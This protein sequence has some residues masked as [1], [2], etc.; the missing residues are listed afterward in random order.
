MPVIILTRSVSRCSGN[1]W[2]YAYIYIRQGGRI[3]N[4]AVAHSFGKRRPCDDIRGLA[5]PFWGR[6]VKGKTGLQKAFLKIMRQITDL[7]AFLAEKGYKHSFQ[8]KAI[9]KE[10]LL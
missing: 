6:F 8:E 5:G 7:A 3:Y 1:C 10:G 9:E 4:R 2:R